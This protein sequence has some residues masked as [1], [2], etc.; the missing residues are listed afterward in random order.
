MFQHIK[1]YCLNVP[2]NKIINKEPPERIVVVPFTKAPSMKAYL[3]TT[4][5]YPIVYKAVDVNTLL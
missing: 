2:Q 1:T 4:A 5:Y 3:R